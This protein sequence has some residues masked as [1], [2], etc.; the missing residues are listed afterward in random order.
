MFRLFLLE[1]VASIAFG[2]TVSVKDGNVFYKPA[3]GDAIQITSSGMDSDA[4]LS[5]DAKLIVFAR[6]TT[7]MKIDTG[8][9]KTG[10]NELWIAATFG[11]EH[12]GFWSDIRADSRKTRISFWP[13]SLGRNS[14]PMQPGYT[15]QPRGREVIQ[16]GEFSGYLIAAS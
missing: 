13:D 14:R 6:R 7:S 16:S 2:Q 1:V 8:L 10:D 4:C 5:Q 3:G 11:A 15:L 9:G 12:A